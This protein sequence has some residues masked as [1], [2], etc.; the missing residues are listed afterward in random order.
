[1]SSPDRQRNEVLNQLTSALNS[2]IDSISPQ[3]VTGSGTNIAYAVR[4]SRD[5]TGV[6]AVTG[7]F[8]IQGKKVEP[9]GPVGFG[10]DEPITKVVLTSIKFDPGMRAAATLQYSD[11]AVEIL[12]DMFLEC[13]T[14]DRK[15]QPPGISTMDWG[16]ASCCKDGVPEVI[17]DKGVSEKSSRIILLGETPADVAGNI[18]MLSNRIINT[19]S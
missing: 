15:H 8:V 9:V 19:E 4:G 10:V 3:L 1:M 2:L 18:I 14:V 16:V 12:N 11:R 13:C 6:A 5:G 17:I 7:G